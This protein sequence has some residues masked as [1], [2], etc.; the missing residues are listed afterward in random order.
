[1]EAGGGH[2]EEN[3]QMKRERQDKD[4]ERKNRVERGLGLGETEIQ[5]KM[6]Y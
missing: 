3:G 5:N 2:T 4:L 6:Q 1:M